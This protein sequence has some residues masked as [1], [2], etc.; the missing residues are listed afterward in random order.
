MPV[1]EI[2]HFRWMREQAL[3]CFRV[4]YHISDVLA[5]FWLHN[6]D[7]ASDEIDTREDDE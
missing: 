2:A 6:A 3:M 7:R 1:T 5:E 4:D